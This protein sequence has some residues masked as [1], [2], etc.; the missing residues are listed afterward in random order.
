MPAYAEQ[1]LRLEER[2]STAEGHAE[3]YR[4]RAEENRWEQCRIVHEA[5]ESGSYSQSSFAREVDRSPGHIR[6]Q[7]EAFRL[8][9][10]RARRPSYAEAIAAADGSTAAQET[11]RKQLS[12][13]RQVLA[14]PKMA[15]Q[16]LDD[17][18]IRRSLMSNDRIR[19]DLT[20]TAHE[21]DTHRAAR[22][23][24]KMRENAPGLEEAREYYDAFA[25]ILH[26]RQDVNKALDL[27][28][29][30]PPLEA[31]QREEMREAV[32]WLSTSLEW[33]NE[34][35]KARRTATLSDEIENYLADQ[36]TAS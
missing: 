33:L 17:P 19:R 8:F 30:L 12:H 31:G 22:V 35:L 24:R 4:T 14:D 28:R 18:D 21:V 23:A 25:R 7:Y 3:E 2:A 11:D 36:G 13:A 26:A 20:R 10:S 32:R 34:T 27:L 9:G 6:R 5:I 16:V 29:S 15:K 1:Y